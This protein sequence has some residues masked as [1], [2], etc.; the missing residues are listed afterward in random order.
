MHTD[1][2]AACAAVPHLKTVMGRPRWITGAL[3]LLLALACR[4]AAHDIP[5]D[6]TVQ[7]FVKPDKQQLRLVVRLPLITLNPNG[8]PIADVDIPRR[9]PDY[10]DLARA[11]VMLRAAAFGAADILKLYENDRLLS[12]P[13]LV[14]ARVSLLS[15]RS[16]VSFD[17]AVAHITG[18]PLAVSTDL[19]WSQGFVDALLEFPIRNDQSDFSIDAKVQSLGGRVLTILRFLPPGGAVRAYEFSGDIGRVRLDP[20]W[21]QAARTFVSAGLLHI[22]EGTDHLLFLFCLVIPIRSFRTLVPVVTSF[23]VA[24]SVTLIASAYRLPPAGAWFPA[25]IETLIAASIVY[26]AVENIVGAK[27]QRRWVVTFC[28]GLIH[29]FGFSFALRDA[30]QFGKSHLLTSLLSFNIGVELGQLIVLAVLI[31]LLALLFRFVMPARIGTIILSAFGAETG[32]RWLGE[33][34]KRLADVEWPPAEI[35]LASRW[36]LLG[37]MAFIA[38]WLAYTG[39]RHRDGMVSAAGAVPRADQQAPRGAT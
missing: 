11:D 34:A 14:A 27:L 7:A 23:T 3:A 2:P 35:L 8:S 15:D 39:F 9:G 32:W 19:P 21:Y 10:L 20:R 18:P 26:M 24:H 6:V 30:L 4:A 31:P 16:F 37:T 36:F 25:T 22:L 33:R 17:D 38:L 29:G 28:F 5:R 13:A 1:L 12:A